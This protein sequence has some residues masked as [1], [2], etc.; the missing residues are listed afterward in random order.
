MQ[1][2]VFKQMKSLRMLSSLM[3]V[4]SKSRK[5]PTSAFTNFGKKNRLNIRFSYMFEMEFQEK[6]LLMSTFSV[7]LWILFTTKKYCLHTLFRLIRITMKIIT[8]RC[9]TMILNTWANQQRNL[10]LK[11][12]STIGPPLRNRWT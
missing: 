1:L 6:D 11:T 5:R 12:T 2:D 10:C 9:R 4:Q 7:E 3:K 8:D